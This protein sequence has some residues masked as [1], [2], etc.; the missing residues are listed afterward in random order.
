MKP[1]IDSVFGASVIAAALLVR[2]AHN[3]GEDC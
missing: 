1:A 2:W 3:M